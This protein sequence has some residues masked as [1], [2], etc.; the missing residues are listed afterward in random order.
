MWHV[1][2]GTVILAAHT[3][4]AL[5]DG[6][7][8]SVSLTVVVQVE[9]LASG[10]ILVQ[11]V[12]NTLFCK[13]VAAFGILKVNERPIEGYHSRVSGLI[14]KRPNAGIP[15]ISL[16]LR[17]PELVRQVAKEPQVGGRLEF[18]DVCE[19]K[20]AGLEKWLECCFV[21]CLTVP[22]WIG[23]EGQVLQGRHPVCRQQVLSAE[24]LSM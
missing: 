3:G 13:W 2:H 23:G 9:Q 11:D 22:G 10:A 16:S 7:V 17:F 21:R 4:N 6:T 24:S 19:G 14:K 18:P 8:D 20:G 5:T 15:F 1:L 12:E